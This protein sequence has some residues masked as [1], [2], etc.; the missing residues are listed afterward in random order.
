MSNTDL[1]LVLAA[2]NTAAS[3]SGD[4]RD[5]DGDGQITVLDARKLDVNCFG[6]FPD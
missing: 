4:P 3:G 2:H 6:N 1:N 5:L